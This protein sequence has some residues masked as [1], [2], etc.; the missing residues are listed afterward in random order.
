MRQKESPAGF[1][2]SLPGFP[3]VNGCGR[4]SAL[5]RSVF[6]LFGALARMV[7]SEPLR[8]SRSSRPWT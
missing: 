8:S 3:F 7:T 5:G 2:E 4:L 1:S 6:Y